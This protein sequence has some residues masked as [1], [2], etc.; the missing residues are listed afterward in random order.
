MTPRYEQCTIF[1]ISEDSITGEQ[2]LTSVRVYQCSIKIGGKTKF[3]DNS[4]SEY[5]PA[6]TFWVRSS[7]LLHGDNVTPKSGDFIV[8]GDYRD[9]TSLPEGSEKIRSVMIHSHAKFGQP[10]SYTIGTSA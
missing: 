8:R 6:S 9:N 5:Y 2:T 7:D 1:R 3:V 10:D 4:G